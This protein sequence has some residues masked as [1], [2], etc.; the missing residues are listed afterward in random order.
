VGRTKWSA[1]ASIRLNGR[2]LALP[3][4]NKG[5][6][7][8]T[9]CHLDDLSWNSRTFDLLLLAGSKLEIWNNHVYLSV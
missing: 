2:A 6:I 8:S 9:H 4:N 3:Y 7:G 5:D 1:G